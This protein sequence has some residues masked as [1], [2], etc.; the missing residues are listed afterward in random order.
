MKTKALIGALILAA[1]SAAPASAFDLNDIL[2]GVKSAASNGTLTDMVQGVF[3][4]S[5]LEVAD[6]AGV[7]TSNGSAVSFK[8][9]DL[10]SKAGGLAAASTI[11]SKLN[12]YYKKYGLTGA[13]FTIQ[14][15]GDFT[16]KVKG[17]TL[18]GTITK[19]SDGNFQFAFTAMKK[20]TLGKVTTYVQKTSSQMDVMFDASKLL[21]LLNGVAKTG[22]LG[23]VSSLLN[24]Y[25]GLCV[26][27]ELKKTGT[28]DGEKSSLGGLIDSVIGSGST[29]SDN[30]KQG[31]TESEAETLQ[32]LKDKLK[33][34]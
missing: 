7:W 1:A 29:N 9:E 34:R 32:K 12:P 26:G 31:T 16:L 18:S 6:L 15:N 25:D 17:T 19:L 5:N 11:E 24:N 27:F 4:T 8:S 28:V 33:K 13:V 14:T 23:S 30:D 10:L 20:L 3:S 2:N 22:I 21:N